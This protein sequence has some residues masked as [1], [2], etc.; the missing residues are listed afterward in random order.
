MNKNEK[1]EIVKQF[2]DCLISEFSK[3]EK[4]VFN[5]FFYPPLYREMLKISEDDF[6]NNSLN[7]FAIGMS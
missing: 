6:V 5:K 2:L 3:E 7:I 1:P 4:R